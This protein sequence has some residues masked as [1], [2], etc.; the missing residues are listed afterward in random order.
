MAV[1]RLE[2]G[3]EFGVRGDNHFKIT[4]VANG[5]VYYKHP[6]TRLEVRRDTAFMLQGFN[7]ENKD[8]YLINMKQRYIKKYYSLL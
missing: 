1:K 8:W 5:N 4:R 2:V 7:D 3:M 6:S